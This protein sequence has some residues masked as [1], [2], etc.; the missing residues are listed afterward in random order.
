MNGTSISK[1]QPSSWC[2]RRS[3]V[4]C[5]RLMV[6]LC[7]VNTITEPLPISIQS[8]HSN[9]HAQHA[10]AI[11]LGPYHT[12]TLLHG[13]KHCWSLVTVG[14][15]SMNST[16]GTKLSGEKLHLFWTKSV[17]LLIIHN[18]V[19]QQIFTQCLHLIRYYK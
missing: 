8:T 10:S 14:S 12:Y 19:A 4:N 9:G 5:K 17:F 15:K 6:A 13:Y 11:Y 18:N 16:P 7:K 2:S 3:Y 1:P